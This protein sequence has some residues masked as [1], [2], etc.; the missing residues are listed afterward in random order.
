MKFYHCIFFCFFCG[1][2]SAQEEIKKCFNKYDL[3]GCFVLYD[4][5]NAGYV[6]Y[7]DII[8]STE[9]LPASTFKIPHALIVLEE[10]HVKDTAE[11]FP[12]NGREW[13]NKNWNQDQ[14]LVTAMK[15]S[16]IWVFIDFAA[17]LGTP[18][19]QKYADA[20][21]YGNKNLTGPVDRFWLAGE[22]A[23]SAN[24]QVD[25]LKRFLSGNLPVSKE[26]INT[27]KDLIVL[28]SAENYNLSGKTGGGRLPAEK[29]IMWLVGYVEN[30]TGTYIFAMN[31]VTDDFTRD[32]AARMNI[33]SDVL[34]E[35]DIIP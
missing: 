34:K 29:Y 31:F 28:E 5:Q 13:P 30:N 3:D 19:Y 12:W 17:K 1:L 4:V 25:F 24:Q 9:Y 16:C 10:G 2:V 7:N 27:V 18:V 35:Y 21:D 15:Y 11:L 8:C 14:T 23:I 26:N 32:Q 22:F 33:T 20:F 6:R